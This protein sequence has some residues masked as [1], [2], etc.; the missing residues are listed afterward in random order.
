MHYSI[1]GREEQRECEIDPRLV[2]SLNLGLN[3]RTRQSAALGTGAIFD[4]IEATENDIEYDY[5][6][7]EAMLINSEEL[8]DADR[9]DSLLESD[10]K[11]NLNVMESSLPVSQ[12]V[13][14]GPISAE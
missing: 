9:S 7:L 1:N 11:D 5:S 4:L 12:R 10:K 8:D 3:R 2:N 14:Q 13:L 6:H